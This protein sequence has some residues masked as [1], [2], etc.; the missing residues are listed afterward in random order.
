MVEKINSFEAVLG[1][2]SGRQKAE[3][4]KNLRDMRAAVSDNWLKSDYF[5]SFMDGYF[6]AL[7]DNFKK[8]YQ[9]KNNL[10][11]AQLQQTLTSWRGVKDNPLVVYLTQQSQVLKRLLSRTDR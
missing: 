1:K 6:S 8:E 10:T 3:V 11:D 7:S 4:E 2:V 5:K 9:A